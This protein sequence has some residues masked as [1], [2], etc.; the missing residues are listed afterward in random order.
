MD[1]IITSTFL[2]YVY[3]NILSNMIFSDDTFSLGS[4]GKVKIEIG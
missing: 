1:I 3:N 2:Y 4:I